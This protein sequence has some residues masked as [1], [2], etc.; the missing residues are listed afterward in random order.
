M[1]FLH[2]L[3]CKLW[4]WTPAALVPSAWRHSI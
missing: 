2:R 4:L 3:V 1:Q